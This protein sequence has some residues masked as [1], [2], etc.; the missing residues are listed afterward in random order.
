MTNTATKLPKLNETEAKC[1]AATKAV[2]KRMFPVTPSV[3]DVADEMGLSKKRASVLLL[4]L[5][6]KGR[7]TR[8]GRK[9]RT[10]RLARRAS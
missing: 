6:E 5:Q 3:Q 2:I 4:Q 10:L 9:S 1:L 8:D 7:V